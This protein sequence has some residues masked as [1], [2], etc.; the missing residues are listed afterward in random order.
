[1]RV[2]N[3]ERKMKKILEAEAK[4]QE[5][6]VKK[7]EMEVLE[8]TSREVA[9]SEAEDEPRMLSP[10]VSNEPVR[11]HLNMEHRLS[12]SSTSSEA[13]RWVPLSKIFHT[14]KNME[15]VEA[16]RTFYAVLALV[17]SRFVC[18]ILLI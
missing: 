16:C 13:N 9:L 4:K 10:N 8:A 7:Y 12:C 1:M 3:F 6:D 2:K 11:P 15:K 18:L 14:A 17:C 5:F